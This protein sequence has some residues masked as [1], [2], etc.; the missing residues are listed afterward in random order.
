MLIS[1]FVEVEIGKLRSFLK[2]SILKHPISKIY[3]QT[4]KK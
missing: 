3:N 2:I 4:K 1:E